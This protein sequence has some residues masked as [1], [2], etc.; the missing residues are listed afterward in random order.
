MKVPV[1]I[2]RCA[3]YSPR[4]LDAAIAASAEMA[5]MPEVSGAS[6]LVK[7][8]LLNASD[9]DRAVTTEPGMLAAVVRHLLERGA[10]RVLVGDSPAWQSQNS[11]GR[12]TGIKDA[13]E[14]SGAEWVD[15]SEGVEMPNP[16]GKMVK[17]FVIAKPF[18]DADLLFDL[19]KLKTHMLTYYTGAIKNLFG[20][21]PGFAK[22]AFHMR[23]PGR[24]EFS[25]M[26]VDLAAL[27]RP[28]FSFM[29][30]I[31]AMEGPGPN[32]GRP[33]HLGLI[34]ASGDPLALDRTAARIIGYDPDS[35]HHLYLALA[36]GIWIGSDE[37]IELPGLG[38]DDV[39]P[40]SFDRVRLAREGTPFSKILPKPI[41]DL[42]RDLSVARPVFDR[43]KCRLCSACVEICP[44]KTLSIAAR[45]AGGHESRTAGSC[46]N[47]DKYIAIDYA[48]C[49]RCY[50]CHEVCPHDAI[51][52][53]KGLRFS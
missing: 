28:D 4:N 20:L 1:S 37:D 9:P 34:L 45:T 16:E 41:H 51:R 43:K 26:L 48:K 7:P 19:P 10:S 35:I 2:L 33:K 12:K 31:V 47:R 14:A 11:V 15:F 50:C 8:N 27:V 52:L 18:V 46:V 42:F 29:D 24:A 32:N 39:K 49:I 22:S 36:R 3:D 5:R 38:I 6:V 17:S 25:A 44:A 40:E 53:A 30:A 23:F 21:V 13:A